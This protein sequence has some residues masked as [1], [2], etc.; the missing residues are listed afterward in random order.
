MR[1]VRSSGSLSSFGLLAGAWLTLHAGE[2]RADKT[3]TAG[4]V[5][6]IA[7]PA[8]A[9]ALT[10]THDDPEGRVQFY[11][12][13]GSTVAAT[14][15]LKQTVHKERPDGSNDESFP[16]GH[17]AGAFQAASFVQRRY[18]DFPAWPGYLLATYTGWTRVEAKKH[19]TSD[20]LAG[21]ALGIGSSFL[22]V[23]R[24]NVSVATTLEPDGFAIRIVA[25]LR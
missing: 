4:D 8:T 1:T 6:G 16:S 5:L 14:W 23:K 21:A 3:E 13:F 10:F 19:F 7:L 12:S 2:V 15:L 24:R 22:F 17:A 18:D 20:V 11:K 25:N 9:F